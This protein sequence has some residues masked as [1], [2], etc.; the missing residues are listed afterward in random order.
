MARGADNYGEG[1]WQKGIPV[2]DCL[3]HALAHIYKYLS[4]DRTEDHLAHAACNMMMACD[5]EGHDG[6]DSK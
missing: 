5:L 3:N 4:G 2:K 6:T 1:N